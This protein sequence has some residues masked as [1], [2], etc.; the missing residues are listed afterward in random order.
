MYVAKTAFSFDVSKILGTTFPFFSKI[1]ILQG[2]LVW[3]GNLLLT[4][5]PIAKHSY[6]ETKLVND[7]HREKLQKQFK[8]KLCKK[9]RVLVASDVCLHN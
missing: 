9:K 8:T 3:E 7:T 5:Y 1:G 4:Q 6:L 2:A